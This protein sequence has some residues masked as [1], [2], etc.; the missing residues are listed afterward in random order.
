[1]KILSAV[2]AVIF[3]SAFL[4]LLLKESL[5]FYKDTAIFGI[6]IGFLMAVAVFQFAVL[7]LIYEQFREESEQRFFNLVQRNILKVI[8]VTPQTGI[9]QV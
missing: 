4:L 6:I 7:H 8:T 5:F 9:A 3:T 1:M 2:L